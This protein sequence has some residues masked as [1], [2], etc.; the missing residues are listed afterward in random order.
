MI[1]MMKWHHINTIKYQCTDL[2]INIIII[3]KVKVHQLKSYQKLKSISFS[4]YHFNWLSFFFLLLLAEVWI[5][6][7]FCEFQSGYTLLHVKL[8]L[9]LFPPPFSICL[10][11]WKFGWIGLHILFIYFVPDVVVKRITIWEWWGHSVRLINVLPI[12]SLNKSWTI[13]AQHDSAL[14]WIKIQVFLFIIRLIS[15]SSFSKC[16]LYVLELTFI[17]KKRLH[18]TFPRYTSR[19]HYFFRLSIGVTEKAIL[20]NIIFMFKSMTKTVLRV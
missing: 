9:P 2:I 20:L 10:T 14:S 13:L 16:F 15:G 11:F 6:L 1:N 5:V 17:H 12:F 3:Y 19:N 8:F 7:K 4:E 18:S